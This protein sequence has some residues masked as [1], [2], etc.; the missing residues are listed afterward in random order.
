MKD[1]YSTNKIGSFNVVFDNKNKQDVFVTE[2]Q[3]RAEDV[4]HE[5]NAGVELDTVL[6]KYGVT[7]K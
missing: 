6:T 5:L 7:E 4:A 3:G 1:Q 2:K